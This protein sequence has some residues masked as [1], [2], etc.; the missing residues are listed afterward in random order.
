MDQRFKKQRHINESM[1]QTILERVKSPQYARM[2]FP[3]RIEVVRPPLAPWFG[4]Q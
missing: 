3:K 2:R 1:P 4:L